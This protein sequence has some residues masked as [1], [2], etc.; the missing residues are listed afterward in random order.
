M[1]ASQSFYDCECQADQSKSKQ[2]ELRSPV[3]SSHSDFGSSSLGKPAVDEDDLKMGPAIVVKPPGPGTAHVHDKFKLLAE[4]SAHGTQSLADGVAL[5][6]DIKT[7]YLALHK[8]L[9]GLKEELRTLPFEDM[10][11]LSPRCG[12]I[13]HD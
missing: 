4:I 8:Q 9:D 6:E 11:W 13:L 3:K 2:K 12:R 10:T 1:P 5:L 7:A